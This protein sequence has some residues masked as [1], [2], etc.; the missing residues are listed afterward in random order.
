MAFDHRQILD[1][2]LLRLREQIFDKP[3]LF[4]LL[5]TKFALRDLQELYE[6]VLGEPLDRRNFR[7]KIAVKHWLRDTGEMEK[8]V[9]HRPGRL[10]TFKLA[11]KR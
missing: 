4:N 11:P 2:C 1:T 3:L 9:V 10:Y 6:S 8:S 7:K 5:P